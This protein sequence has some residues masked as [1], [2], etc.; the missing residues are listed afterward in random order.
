MVQMK[1]SAAGSADMGMM[2]DLQLAV[3]L[4]RLD[5]ALTVLWA[6]TAFYQ[7]LGKKQED[8]KESVVFSSCFSDFIKDYQTLYSLLCAAD[9][10]GQRQVKLRSSMMIA[11]ADRMVEIAG[12]IRALEGEG[13]EILLCYTPMPK[14]LDER[15]QLLS[16]K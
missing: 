13:Q 16:V 7:M 9:Q 10:H 5:D 1:Q 12:T 3:S 11:G 6:N 4:H 2:E 14:L 15:E 8:F